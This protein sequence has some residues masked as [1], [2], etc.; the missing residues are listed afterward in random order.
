M[1]VRLPYESRQQ[2]ASDHATI[3]AV[4]RA[5]TPTVHVSEVSFLAF[6]RLCV[7]MRGDPCV[8]L[9]FLQF[10]DALTRVV[11]LKSL[12]SGLSLRV[13]LEAFLRRLLVL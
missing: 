7:S 12:G 5:Y 8:Q 13:R 4:V 10:C 1:D 3:P 11:D 9:S 6:S 2:C